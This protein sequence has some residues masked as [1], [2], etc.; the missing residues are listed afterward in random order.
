MQLLGYLL[1]KNQQTKSEING[2]TENGKNCDTLLDSLF[3]FII[4]AREKYNTR[5]KLLSTH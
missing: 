4:V 3:V 5:I 2:E 1:P